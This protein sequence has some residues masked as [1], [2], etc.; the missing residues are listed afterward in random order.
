MTPKLGNLGENF[1]L[2]IRQ[3]ATFGP[4]IAT[5]VDIT[6]TPVNLSDCEI[7]GQIRKTWDAPEIIAS[8]DVAITDAEKGEW[9]FSLTDDVTAALLC[10]AELTDYDSTY[11]YD[12]EIEWTTPGTV[13]PLY[14]GAVNVFREITR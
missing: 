1:D 8:F 6:L 11:V 10:G 4:I 9:K 14:Y 13:W 2:L 3:G 5:M 7:R 12:I